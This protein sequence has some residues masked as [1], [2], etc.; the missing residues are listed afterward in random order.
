M[1]KVRILNDGGFGLSDVDFPVVVNSIPRKV[2]NDIIGFDVDRSEFG[3][4]QS[5]GVKLY[6]SMMLGECE[7]L[8]DE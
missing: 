8:D 4:T 5:V 6:F 7:V 3:D 1:V 2:W